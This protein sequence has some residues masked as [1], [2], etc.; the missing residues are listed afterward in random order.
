MRVRGKMRDMLRKD[1][2]GVGTIRL[3]K[4]LG[5]I[6]ILEAEIV[7][8]LYWRVFGLECGEAI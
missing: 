5:K 3:S 1:A 2:P 6:L 7:S 4:A 8:R